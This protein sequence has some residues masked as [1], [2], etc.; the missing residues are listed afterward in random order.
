M[1]DLDSIVQQK[2][3]ALKYATAEKQL[4]LSDSNFYNQP[5]EVQQQAITSTVQKEDAKNMSLTQFKE[6]YGGSNPSVNPNIAPII[7]Q[8]MDDDAAQVWDQ[9]RKDQIASIQPKTVLD[10]VITGLKIGTA[11]V[12]GSTTD[13]GAAILPGKQETL[14]NIGDWARETTQAAQDD[15][16]T[17]ALS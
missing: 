3:I 14:N 13:L 15:Y 8:E 11:N 6:T 10:D 2:Q 7:R 9:V 12:I 5:K 16:S 4:A 17:T 1:A